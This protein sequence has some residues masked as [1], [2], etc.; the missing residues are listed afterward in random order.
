MK[1][2]ETAQVPVKNR[3]KDRFSLHRETIRLLSPA[4][5]EA[6][7][8]AEYERLPDVTGSCDTW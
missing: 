4:T 2:N 5:L 6:A 3:K 7:K 1:K 8:G